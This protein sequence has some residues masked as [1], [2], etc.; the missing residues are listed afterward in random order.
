MNPVNSIS[1]QNF[2]AVG[3]ILLAAGIYY[4]TLRPY[5]YVGMFKDDAVY[6]LAA[7]S[8]SRGAYTALSDLALPARPHFPPGFSLF[9][10]PF[11]LA[12]RTHYE[13]LK[14]LSICLVLLS[15][16]L[17][18]SLSRSWLAPEAGL[19]VLVLYLFN[20]G[21]TFSSCLVMS[22]PLFI[23][24]ALLGF[25]V[26][27][28]TL[29]KSH[30]TWEPWILGALLGYA[31]LVRYT[32][33]ALAAGIVAGLLYA[34]HRYEAVVTGF[35]AGVIEGGWLFWIYGTHRPVP[36]I[37]D[38]ETIRY[39]SGFREGF[40]E[41]AHWDAFIL[42]LQKTIHMIFVNDVLSVPDTSS[43][44]GLALRS[45][46]ALFVIGLMAWGLKA[47]KTFTPQ[48]RALTFGVI[49]YIVFWFGIHLSWNASYS[50]YA[51]PTLPL[52]LILLI[53]GA[54]ALPSIGKRRYLWTAGLVTLFISHAFAQKTFLK[55]LR[56]S[57]P[58][59]NLPAATTQWIQQHAPEHAL[60]LCAK[61]SELRLYTAHLGYG[62]IAARSREQFRYL[63][64]ARNV[65]YIW[66]H[67]FHSTSLDEAF[68]W[69]ENQRWASSWPDAFKEVFERPDEASAVY[70]VKR[71]ERFVR[72]YELYEQ[73]RQD[74]EINAYAEGL[75]KL[76][77]AL[78]LD[79]RL[80]S[81]LNA[82]AVGSLQL[83]KNLSLAEA[84]LKEAIHLE[85]DHAVALYNLARVYK[86]LGRDGLAREYL[87]KAKAAAETTFEFQSA[88]PMILQGV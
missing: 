43:P 48:K 16:G 80:T 60:V 22:E 49:L 73:A 55:R 46:L 81:A 1:R 19:L 32:G 27:R 64:L 20:A 4:S 11:V 56:S 77:R 33:V 67:P 5:Y 45:V 52:T 26:F 10:V 42:Q 50:R 84:K 63:L 34:K 29:T 23:C 30:A 24:L 54:A 17:M 8:L 78:A 88:L 53:A 36:G 75:K 68:Y 25:L 72:A 44:A 14:W 47:W 37:N 12:A 76:N 86:R 85:P 28:R 41:F 38:Q 71:D 9:L 79:P 31:M 40:A 7:Q 83:N 74:F 59:S 69:M 35:V 18:F 70:E 58:E 39:F 21:T 15:G 66:T 51:L 62:P 6:I 57:G 65:S 2:I 82:Y 61:P 13:I 3:F 87:L